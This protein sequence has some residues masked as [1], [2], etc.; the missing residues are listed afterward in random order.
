MSLRI[1]IIA[2]TPEEA[3]IVK[4]IPGINYASGNL[5]FMDKEINILVTG[6]GTVATAWAMTKMISSGTRPDLAINIGIA[7]AFRK[8]IQIGRV[9]MPVSEC[10]ADA[11]VDSG[12][13]FMT[14]SEA[15]LQDPERFP[16][17]GGRLYSENRYVNLISGVIPSVSAIT[18]NTASGTDGRIRHLEAKFNPDIET[19]EGAAFFYVCIMEGIPFIALRSISNRVEVRNKDNWNIPLALKSLAEGLKETLLLI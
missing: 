1:S 15:G 13:G 4:V 10:F 14:L 6:V 12:N 16:F 11:G 5:T 18:V 17:K 2:A 7:G 19:M 9:V 8:D 3:E